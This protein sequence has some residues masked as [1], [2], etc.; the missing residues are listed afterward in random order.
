MTSAAS[1]FPCL[2][3]WIV[4]TYHGSRTDELSITKQ[5]RGTMMIAVQ[6][7]YSHCWC[8]WISKGYLYALTKR[9]LLDNEEDGIQKL[10]KFH[11]IVQL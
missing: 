3:R 6:K 11:E 1:A 2:Y 5:S 4:S 10:H 7:G 9:L 8:K